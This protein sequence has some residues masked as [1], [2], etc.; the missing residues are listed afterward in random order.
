MVAVRVGQRKAAEMTEE[1]EATGL[2]LV[3]S[4]AVDVLLRQI[5]TRELLVF[6]T[7][8]APR[9]SRTPH[10]ATATGDRSRPRNAST[11][12]L[13]RPPYPSGFRE[14]MVKL[15]RSGRSPEELAREFEPPSQSIRNW[16]SQ[17]DCDEG[18]SNDGLTSAEREE[19][20][21]LRRENRQLRQEREILARAAAWF[22]PSAGSIPSGSSS[23]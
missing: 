20:R 18:R 21:R 12:S 9:R 6:C 7:P 19:L 11:M 4:D 13:T 14:Q 15:V 5:G 23:S 16:V 2:T 8:T 3:N 17:V 1:M 22:A 10:C